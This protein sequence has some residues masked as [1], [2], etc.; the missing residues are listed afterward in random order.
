MK[1]SLRAALAGVAAAG[2]ALGVAEVIAVFTGPLSS[3]LLAV[4]GV[5][6]DNVPAPVKDAGIAVFGTHDKTAL[7]TGTVILLG[8]YAALLGVIALRS[9]PVALGGVVLFGAVGVTAAATRHDAGFSAVVPSIIATVVAAVALHYLVTLAVAGEESGSRDLETVPATARKRV[10]ADPI[11]RE[12]S[13]RR[14]LFVVGGAAAVAAVGGVGGRF[15]TSRRAVTAARAAVV[16]P[17]PSQAAPAVPAGVQV[18]GAVPYVTSNA[19]FYRIDTALYPPQIDPSTWELRIHGMVRNPITITWEQL[20]QRPM[21]QRYVTLACVSNEVGDDLI[22]NALWLGTSIKDLLDEAE[23]LPGADQ[24]V[25]RSSDGW[26]CGSP[27]EVL[28]DGRDALLAI[29]MNGQ[30]LPVAH[31]F[32]VRMV[33]PGL[34]GYVSACKWITEIELTRFSDFDAYWVPRGWSALGPIKTQ[35][36]IDTPRDGAKR[37]AG[38]V[39]VAG[40]AWAQHRG[41]EKVEV[42]VDGGPWAQATL[43]SAVSSDTWV[44]WSYQWQATSGDHTV[45]VRATDKDGQTQTSTPA[46]PAPDGATGWHSVQV[47]VG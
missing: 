28:R 26:T 1:L 25:Q 16:L 22:G 47:T 4:G 41:I 23:P 19:D 40:V 38:P 3:P 18:Q 46:P 13:R 5:V 42:Q 2:V 32:P 44:Q 14:F 34:Y 8:L 39:T 37:S 29:G 20:L 7:I 12:D 9:R 35:S 21:V 36:R 45:Q 10:T 27:T 30:P 17:L 11:T 24:V 15:L 33:V 43:A 6:V 31:G